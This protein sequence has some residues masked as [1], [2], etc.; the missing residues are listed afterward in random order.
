VPI[1]E[2]IS[3]GITGGLT[4]LSAAVIFSVLAASVGIAKRGCIDLRGQHSSVASGIFAAVSVLFALVLMFTGF[5][6]DIA[7]GNICKTPALIPALIPAILV[8]LVI[9]IYKAASNRSSKK[10]I[11]HKNT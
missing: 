2:M 3:P 1:S 6:A 8:F 9:C 7:N 11:N 4:A 10:Y 5:G